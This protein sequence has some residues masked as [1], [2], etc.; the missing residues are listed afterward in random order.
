MEGVGGDVLIAN[1]LAITVQ[2]R[3]PHSRL[4]YLYD[5]FQVQGR[6]SYS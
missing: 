4:P 5:L 2:L 6:K 1:C 3:F